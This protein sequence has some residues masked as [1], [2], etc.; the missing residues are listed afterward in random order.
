M[1]TGKAERWTLGSEADPGGLAGARK[2]KAPQA[3]TRWGFGGI[4]LDCREWAS[5]LMQVRARSQ[6]AD[7]KLEGHSHNVTEASLE[8]G[9]LFYDFHSVLTVLA[10]SN[11]SD[12]FPS[13][14]FDSSPAASTSVPSVD[15]GDSSGCNQA[16]A[17]ASS[18]KRGDAK[19]LA[20][21]RQG[22][23]D[24]FTEIFMARWRRMVVRLWHRARW[25]YKGVL[26]WFVRQPGLRFLPWPYPSVSSVAQWRTQAEAMIESRCYP[27]K[28][29]VRASFTA[30]N[31]SLL[32]WS[33]GTFPGL[34]RGPDPGWHVDGAPKAWAYD[35]AEERC[36]QGGSREA[37]QGKGQTQ[38]G[39]HPSWTSWW[40]SDFEERLDQVG[41]AAA[42]GGGREGHG[43][44]HSEQAETRGRGLV[45]TCDT[46]DHPSG[47]RRLRGG[48]GRPLPDQVL[49]H[50]MQVQAAP[51]AAQTQEFGEDSVMTEASGEWEQVI[52]RRIESK[53]CR[54]I[55]LG[56][57]LL[58]S[59]AWDRRRRD[60]FLISCS[61]SQVRKAMAD[62]RKELYMKGIHDA[63]I[64]EIPVVCSEVYSDTEPV[65]RAARSRG[66][67]TGTTIT[68][69]FDKG[70]GGWLS[71]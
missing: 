1:R 45:S 49:H 21:A 52:N 32:A 23:A 24:E 30:S 3:G 60:Q 67:T 13:E 5:H 35:S 17:D 20:R 31:L 55:K 4:H 51:V 48:N 7:A 41:A 18:W 2:R 65:V 8:L 25:S 44:E 61:P 50:M 40:P 36:H 6:S 54:T 27:R 15:H 63:F 43:A 22:V 39:A 70:C 34:L 62:E 26:L 28:W 66:H 33:C 56:Q 16:C 10:Q 9:R 47:G 37:G 57:R 69:M 59:Q 46:P 11:M 64:M 12:D 58:L 71:S 29:L 53:G 42:H 19:R 38:S 14:D 68:M